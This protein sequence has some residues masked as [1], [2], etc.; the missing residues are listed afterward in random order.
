MTTPPSG[1]DSSRG[2]PTAQAGETEVLGQAPA[3]L[4]EAFF[5]LTPPGPSPIV[6]RPSCLSPQMLSRRAVHLEP[7][8]AVPDQGRRPD[9]PR[10]RGS[11]AL[12]EAD[13]RMARSDDAGHRGGHR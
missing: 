8:L 9:D 5:E 6:R 10:G 11:G 1:P 7:E 12:P 13:A 4:A 2:E 3:R